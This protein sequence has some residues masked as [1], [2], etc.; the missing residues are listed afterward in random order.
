MKFRAYL[1]LAIQNYIKI[2]HVRVYIS[3]FQNVSLHGAINTSVSVYD[4]Y[5]IFFLT[6]SKTL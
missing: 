3:A 6:K 4:I 1:K 2:L 5:S